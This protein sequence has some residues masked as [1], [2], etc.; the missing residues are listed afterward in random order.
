MSLVVRDHLQQILVGARLCVEVLSSRSHIKANQDVIR[1]LSDYLDQAIESGNDLTLD[2]SP[3]ILYEDGL[4]PALHWLVRQMQMKHQL[5]VEVDTH[6]SV[7][8]SNEEVRVFLFR[9]VHELLLNVIQH[10]GVSRATVLMGRAN[11]DQLQIVVSDEGVGF[12]PKKRIEGQFP[13]GGFGLLSIQ[14]RLKLLG[15][16]MEINSNPSRGCRISMILPT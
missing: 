2:L 4:A 16:Q 7:E 13:G 10:S 3:P 14:E 5:Q 6:A 15:G 8:P 9:A 11:H 12:D 1:Q